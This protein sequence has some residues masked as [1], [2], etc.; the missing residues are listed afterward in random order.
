[1]AR[2]IDGK[3]QIKVK[4]TDGTYSTLAQSDMLAEILPLMGFY[5]RKY[6]KDNIILSPL[7]KEDK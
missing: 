4:E 5:N 1:M 6:G 7:D 2:T 3:Y